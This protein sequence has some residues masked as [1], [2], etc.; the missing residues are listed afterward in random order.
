MITLT[1]IHS[2]LVLLVLTLSCWAVS[3]FSPMPATRL[4]HHHHHPLIASAAGRRLQKGLVLKAGGF[5]WEDPTEAFDQGVENP[6]KN[7]DLM[8]SSEGEDMQIDPARLLGPR[9]NGSNLYLYVRRDCCRPRA[10]ASPA[11][12]NL[13]CDGCFHRY[14]RRIVLAFSFFPELA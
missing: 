4:H 11:P 14:S 6:F 13:V 2:Q 8:K 10:L 7:P 5:E 9:L 3:A 1:M 12:E